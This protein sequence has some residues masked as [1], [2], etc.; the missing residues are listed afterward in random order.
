MTYTYSSG[1]DYRPFSFDCRPAYGISY[2]YYP[3][4]ST[5]GFSIGVRYDYRR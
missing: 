2:G 1:Y 3:R 5:S 4:Y